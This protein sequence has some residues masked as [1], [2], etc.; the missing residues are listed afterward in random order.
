M[1]LS[2]GLI[3]GAGWQSDLPTFHATAAGVIQGSLE[4]FVREFSLEQAAAWREEIP[5]LQR[6]AGELLDARK[7]AR[8]YGA[9]LEYLMPYDGRRPDAI[10]LADGA[11][12]V[13]ELKGKLSP[14]QADLDQ[15]AA[16]ARDLRAYHRECHNRDVRAILVPTKARDSVSESD[17]VM[18]VAPDRLDGVV[19]DLAEKALGDGPAL[20]DFLHDDAYCPLP[21]LVQAARELFESRT[22]REIWRA[23]AATEPAVEAITD[24]AH[25]AARAKTRHLV[26]V[27]GVP[28]S[29][30][31]LVGMRAVHARFLDDLAVEREGGKPAVP[32]LYLT[33]NQPLSEVLQYELKQAGGGGRTFVRH[34]KD[35]LN[36]YIPKPER[37]PPEHLLVFDEA[38]RAFSPEKVADTHKNWQLKWIASEPELFI[39]VCD[40]MPEWS[41]IVGLIGG[42]Q[43]IHLGE[44]EGLGQWRDALGT[45]E[46]EWVVHAPR[47]VADVFAGARFETRWVD[48]LSLDT[49]IRFHGATRLHEFVE[50]L[51]GSGEAEGASS[52]AESVSAPFGRPTDGLRLYLTRD[53]EQAKQY[54]RDRYAEYPQARYGML[55]SSRDKMLPDFGIPNDYQST[56]RVR[57]GPWFTEA[58]DDER[59]CRRLEQAVTEFGCQGL[60]LEMA[61]VGWGT[62]LVRKDGMW[63]TDGARR[64][65]RLG[66]CAVRDPFQMRLNAYRVLLTRGRDGTIVFVPALAELDETW[67]YLRAAGFRPLVAEDRH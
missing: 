46:Q 15:A 45:S 23:R 48:A 20:E 38:Q 2:E 16:Y 17:G 43:E 60:E 25:E 7:E 39:R 4:D 36:R 29:G 9:V 49:E 11:V 66:R 53:L 35:Y 6:E 10:V 34:I 44:E 5:L 31:T 64:Y 22:V 27:T 13:L 63:N 52:I 3:T 14:S 1:I 30:K 41:V 57:I 62:D 54:M 32:G 51:L 50:Q 56:K 61:L 40:R 19:G 33:G 65:R 26:L 67:D 47:A 58:E 18:V 55:A 28:G 59:S 12:V 42:G 24:I 21:T 37:V 8:G